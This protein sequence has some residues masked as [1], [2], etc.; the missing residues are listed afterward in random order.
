MVPPSGRIKVITCSVLIKGS[1]DSRIF[2][3]FFLQQPLLLEDG[4]AKW[5]LEYEWLVYFYVSVLSLIYIISLVSG[6]GN[7]NETSGNA[8][9]SFIQ[10]H[11]TKTWK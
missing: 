4:L 10:A 8:Q 9:L 3:C 11:S 7:I 6:F 2:A 1:V 5:Q